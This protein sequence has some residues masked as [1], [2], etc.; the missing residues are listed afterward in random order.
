MIN[1]LQTTYLNPGIVSAESSLCATI[2][3]SSSCVLWFVASFQPT[4][5]SHCDCIGKALQHHSNFQTSALKMGSY[6]T[7]LEKM[8]TL[9]F[10][11]HYICSP[12]CF[13]VVAIFIIHLQLALIGSSSSLHSEVC[14]ALGAS[15][16]VNSLNRSGVLSICMIDNTLTIN[17]KPKWHCVMQQSE[18][19]LHGIIMYLRRLWFIMI[20]TSISSRPFGYD[21]V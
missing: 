13:V 15:D 18:H 3:W 11:I 20:W 6:T 7:I 17:F 14:N 2:H 4:A 12:S 19:C 16:G 1:L 9:P 10:K 21:Q 5:R 8:L